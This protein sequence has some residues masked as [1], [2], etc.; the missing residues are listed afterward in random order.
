[1]L[2]WDAVFVIAL[3]IVS[4]VTVFQHFYIKALE[5]SRDGWRDLT[6][7]ALRKER[8]YSSELMSA[9]NDDW[10]NIV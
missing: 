2:P 7:R 4:G 9:E 1:M 10:E 6:Y 5:R 8:I 3:L